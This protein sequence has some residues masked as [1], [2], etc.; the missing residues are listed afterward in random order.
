VVGF[1]VV[2]KLGMK[3]EQR[4]MERLRVLWAGRGVKAFRKGGAL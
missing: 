3:A 2:A 4:G 1:F